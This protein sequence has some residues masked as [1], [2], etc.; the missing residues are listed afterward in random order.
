MYANL[1]LFK[2]QKYIKPKDYETR[3]NVRDFVF[4]NELFLQFRNNS[5][6]THTHTHTHTCIISRYY[7]HVCVCKC[8]AIEWCRNWCFL[9]F[10]LKHISKNAQPMDSWK[11]ICW[12][13]FVY[14]RTN[15]NDDG[16]LS[17]RNAECF[18]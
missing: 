4:F 18:M 3:N 13:L 12:L 9:C 11:R 1:I 10:L 5:I 15:I 8:I 16:T 14:L 6:N 7:K 2:K 17:I